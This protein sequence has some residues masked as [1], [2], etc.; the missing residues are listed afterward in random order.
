MRFNVK[1]EDFADSNSIDLICE[2][3]KTLKEEGSYNLVIEYNNHIEE[4]VFLDDEF[5]EVKPEHLRY[6]KD[7]RQK[8]SGLNF[9]LKNIY[10]LGQTDYSDAKGLKVT[11]EKTSQREAGKNIYWPTKQMFLYDN[12]KKELDARLQTNEI[13]FDEYETRLRILQAEMG[14][15]DSLEEEQY[16]H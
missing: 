8:C 12:G 14:F 3:L 4:L 9:E 5:L 7:C 13:D 6:L 11:L 16:I 15:M 1:F 10:L 2:K